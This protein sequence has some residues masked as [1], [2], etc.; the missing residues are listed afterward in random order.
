MLNIKAVK[1]RVQFCVIASLTAR[2]HQKVR[3]LSKSKWLV[4]PITENHDLHNLSHMQGM[5]SRGLLS[6][7]KLEMHMKFENRQY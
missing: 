7:W 2:V 4:Q 1:R 6:A 5:I 3:S